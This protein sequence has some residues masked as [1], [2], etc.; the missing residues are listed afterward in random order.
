MSE[1]SVVHTVST[2]REEVGGTSRSVTQLCDALAR[3]GLRVSLVSQHSSGADRGP[4]LSGQTSVSVS[5]VPL[6]RGLGRLQ[7]ASSFRTALE[8]AIRKGTCQLIHDHGVWLPSNFIASRVAG[9][10]GIPFVMS[11][12]GM[13]ESWALSHHVVRKR[14]AWTLY[15]KRIATEAAVVRATS[16][17]EVESVRRLGIRT[18]VAVIPNGIQIPEAIEPPRPREKTGGKR[19]LL[20][21]RIHK[22]KGVVELLEAW[23]R[24]RPR[25]WTLSIVGPGE[26]RYLEKVRRSIARLD[27]ARCVTLRGLVSDDEKWPLY[28][29][30][31]LFILPSFSESFGLVI[32]E[33]LA[34]G[35]PVITTTSTPWKAVAEHRCGWW[36]SMGG[37]HA[38]LAAALAEATTRSPAELQDMGRNGRRLI[39]ERY[40]WSAAASA[41][42]EL[43]DWMLKGGATPRFVHL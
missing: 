22:V 9:K 30:A 25:D 4:L 2:L 17:S 3:E 40:N 10:F 42:R 13:L 6:G 18:P 33:A 35:L 14:I 31:D 24:V 12:H 34:S 43:Y 41:T 37:D 15:Q 27:L 29:S 16:E 1:L 11:P 26:E 23:A 36:I 32:G 20:L 19:A 38:P 5:M 28:A 39:G 8:A 21:S 7:Y